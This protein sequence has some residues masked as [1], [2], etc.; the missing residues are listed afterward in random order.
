MIC[1]YSGQSRVQAQRQ[2]HEVQ[3]RY[4]LHGLDVAMSF[5]CPSLRDRAGELMHPFAVPGAGPPACWRF[6][7]D[8]GTD[9]RVSLAAQGFRQLWEQPLPG[10]LVSTGWALD[11]S[12]AMCLDDAGVVR[13]QFSQRRVDIRVHPGQ[14]CSMNLGLMIPALCECL[15]TMNQHACHAACI[16]LPGPPAR[17]AVLFGGS[18][19]GKTTTALA[20]HR[21]GLSLMTDDCAFLLIDPQDPL[22]APQAWGFPRPCKVHRRTFE[23]LGWINQVLPAPRF[24]NDECVVPF[25]QLAA[26]DAQGTSRP[27]LLLFLQPR[28]AIAHR[29]ES[30]PPVQAVAE[31]MSHIFRAPGREGIGGPASAMATAARVAGACRA[32]RLSV[33]PDLDTLASTI[34][35]ATEPS[36]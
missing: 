23:L 35:A 21:S 14:E 5:S 34:L 30:I 17:C 9:G 26:I 20:L 6:D 33:G 4:H 8:Y 25:S 10:G 19:T 7:V 32:L 16:R 36:K 29:L 2:E 22:S 11:G 15:S 1:D 3:G 31:L 24:V 12:R 13:V 27:A 28:N 18:G